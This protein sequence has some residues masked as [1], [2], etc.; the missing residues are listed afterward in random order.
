MDTIFA[1]ATASGK[2]GVAIVRLSGPYAWPVGCA[3]AGSLPEAGKSALRR[4]K[5]H[6]GNLLDDALVLCFAKGGSFTGEDVVELHLHGSPA[7]VKKVLEELSLIDGVRVAEP[8]EFT[9]QALENGC[10]DLAQVEGLGDLIEAET[11]VQRI[12]AMR[13]FDGA[14]GAKADVWRRDLIRAVSLLE[15]TIDFVDEDVPVDVSPEVLS[16]LEF[17]QV[18]LQTESDG[19]RISERVRDGFEVAII[20]APNVGKSTLLNRLAGRDAALTSRI[21]GTT[22]DVIEVRM[23]LSGLPVTFLDTAGLRATD[24]LVENLGIA[25]AVS[26]AKT[27]DLRVFLVDETGSVDFDILPEPTDLIVFGKSD[28][29]LKAKELSVSGITGNGV[30]EL[31]ERIATVLGERASGAATATRARHRHAIDQAIS[32]LESARHVVS[33]EPE[34]SELASEDIHQAVRALDSLIGRVDVEHVLDEIFAS[35]CLG[36]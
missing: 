13:V 18:S 15:A 3:M 5:D 31:V 28:L 34:R 27:A 2:A 10:L 12:Q 23:E 20:G 21:A 25:L 29:L 22:R 36:K 1:L 19:S 24:D 32:L 17:T 7:I 16:L 6:S 30:S 9:R 14:L 8:G 35:F 26:R 33:E 4:L 11:E